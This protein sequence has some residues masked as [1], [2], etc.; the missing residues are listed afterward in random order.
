VLEVDGHLALGASHEASLGDPGQDLVHERRSLA[1]PPLL[2]GVLDLA[3]RLDGAGRGDELPAVG[4]LA[5]DGRVSLDRQMS[6]VETEPPGAGE[7]AGGE[8]EQVAA[9]ISRS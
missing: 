9:T 4:Q 6:V 3:Q 1:D 5:R 7:R 8:L 2:L